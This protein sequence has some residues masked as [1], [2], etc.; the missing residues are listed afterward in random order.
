MRFMLDTNLCVDLMRGKAAGAFKRLGSLAMDEAGISTITFAELRYGAEKSTRRAYHE[1]LI[2]A[3]CAPLTIATF[4]ARAAEVYGVIRA[5][6]ESAGTPIGPLDTLIGA[7]A[8]SLGAVV[9]TANTREFQRIPGLVV[10]NWR[11]P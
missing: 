8:L 6:L 1:A 7:H 9:V 4:D 10:E 2:V 3:F 5:T 11:L